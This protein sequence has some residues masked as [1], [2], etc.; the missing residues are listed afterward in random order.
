MADRAAPPA[1]RLDLLARTELNRRVIEA[2]PGGVVHVDRS[3][4]ILAANGEALRVLGLS[5]DALTDKYTTDFETETIWEDGTPCPAAEY[6]VTRALVT[7]EPQKPAT[8]GVRRP[9]GT[10]SWAVF[11]AT[12]LLDEST[13]EVT[14][15]VVTFFDVT[16]QKRIARESQRSEELLR[17]I[18]A[19][20]PSPIATSDR[21]GTLLVVNRLP[22]VHAVDE[23]IGRPA[24]YYLVR[25]DQQKAKDA[26]ARIVATGKPESYEALGVSGRRWLV[27]AG[28]RYDGDEIAGVTFV[29]WDV[30]EQ[31]ELERRVAI[32]DRMASIGQLAASVAHEVNNPLTYLMVNLEWL[33]THLAGNPQAEERLAA[34]THGAGRIRDVVADLRT[35]SQVSDGRRVLLEVRHVV[36]GALRIAQGETR[37]RARVVT[38]YGEA[39]PVLANEGRLGQVFLNLI[40]NA[41]QAIPE[42]DIAHHEIRVST[43]VD[44]DGRVVV[45][46]SDTGA[47]IPAAQLPTIFDAFVTTKEGE[48]TG[49]GL[50]ICREVVTSL[51]GE[52]TVTSTPGQGSTFRVALPPASVALRTEKP[53][54]DAP[55]VSRSSRRL[56]VLVADDEPAIVSVL[57]DCLAE[58]DVTAVASGREALERLEAESFDFALCDI[59]MTDLTG[60][61]VYERLRAASPGKEQKLVFMSGGAFTERARQFLKSIPNEVI[62]KPFTC[63]DVARVVTRHEA[64]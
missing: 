26:I 5:H 28:P 64:R 58:H 9:D 32:A 21:E 48:G 40:I 29:T 59:G 62:D 41:A 53:P 13:K 15:V 42:G 51:S 54:S 25:E 43:G 4:A 1:A 56:R 17:S 47:G 31:R 49:L 37:C 36:E 18:L 33:R 10:T 24:W 7:G 19:G 3:G 44:D 12:P 55:P 46:I 6:P 22:K 14:G 39:P 27:H 35:F 45:E 20:A 30:T 11:T 61:D 63:A 38:S 16:E 57:L 2:M 34:A 8:I 60:M 52:I 50:Y 23:A